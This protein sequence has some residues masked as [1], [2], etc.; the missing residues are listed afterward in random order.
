V[1]FT[2][3]ALDYDGTIARDGTLDADVRSAIADVRSRGITVL[4]VTGRILDD[5]RRIA[6]DLRFV[7]AIVAE[8]GAVITFPDSGQSA[9]LAAPVPKALTDDLRES[10]VPF[11][12]GVCVI[13]TEA[14]F[15][16]RVVESIR[17][18]ELPYAVVFNRTRAMIL[19]TGVN[20]AS[21]L[22]EALRTLRLSVHNAIALGD[23]ENDHDLLDAA[24]LGVAVAWGSAALKE[25][26]DEVLEGS[27]PEAV[28][29]YIRR[30]SLAPR[31]PPER[32]GRRRLMLGA[33]ERGRQY[34]LSVRGRNLLIVGD[35]KSG[36]SWVAG[37]LCEHLI[38]H[39]YSVCV[40]DP[41]GDYAGLD[42]LPGVVVLGETA[43]GPT[44]AELRSALRYPDVNVVIELSRMAHLEKW[45]Y[46][47]SL[48][49]GLAEM[50][51][52]F[53]VPHRIILDEAHYLLHEPAASHLLDLELAGYTLVTYQPSRLS[54]EVR[55][56]TEAVVATRLSDP[57]EIDALALSC[58]V[59]PECRRA[60]AQLEIGEAAILPVTREVGGR[61]QVVRLASR[62]TRHV[63]H[64]EKYLDVPVP[65]ERAFVFMA[66]G[67]ELSR[68]H[69]LRQFVDAIASR[70]ITALDRHLVRSDFSQWIADVYGDATTAERV[71]TLEERYRS[72][73]LPDVND[74]IASVIEQRYDLASSGDGG[75]AASNPSTPSPDRAD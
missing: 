4:I 43:A 28:A 36:K 57:R 1:R 2:V 72:G 31:I 41:E 22:R 11:E 38:Q 18:V 27:G 29:D 44:P 61:L 21:G 37:L 23:A 19:P 42:A 5:L 71:R 73:R 62:L 7:D 66:D 46:I 54:P 6:G 24:E 40:I 26:A 70:P 32:V 45:S 12:T 56:A 10:G 9:T 8:N 50:R 47:R 67:H 74:A 15:A 34:S 35:P 63:R 39:R 52:R 58:S 49:T 53:G 69:T 17:R 48:L 30:A 25:R 60:L 59:P 33:D 3:L 13:E 14:A 68:A 75:P 64:R 16:P 65:T 51:R 20:K 55:Q